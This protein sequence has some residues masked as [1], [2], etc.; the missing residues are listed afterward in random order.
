MSVIGRKTWVDLLRGVAMTA[1]LFFHTDVY[2]AD[3]DVLGYAFY[4]QNALT[5][6]FFLSGYLF[7]K[8]TDFSSSDSLIGKSFVR[9]K[10]ASVARNLMIPYFVFAL[11]LS[12]PKAYVRQIPLTSLLMDILSGRAFWFVAALI[13]AELLF[14]LVLRITRG[15]AWGLLT[16]AV[17][18][19]VACVL[20]ST[21]GPELYADY[22]WQAENAIMAVVFLCLGWLF[23][24][25]EAVFDRF[26]R[27]SYISLL[28]LLTIIIKI[29]EHRN[30]ISMCIEP[31]LVSHWTLFY[32]DCITVTILMLC[33][34][35]RMPRVKLTE[36]TG[37]HSIVYYFFCSSVPLAVSLFLGKA[38]LPYHGSIWRAL[39]AFIIAYAAITAIAWVI[40]RYLPFI[41]GHGKGK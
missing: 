38:G 29:Y 30:S 31:I 33:V 2:Y 26:N 25:Y 14:L 21:T 37:A 18:A 4:V 15:K 20:L 24:R 16:T 41:I 3:D 11:I 6:F 39:V 34:V 23:H 22:P 12:V 19:A 8:E 32:A 7:F 1:I 36:W 5:I 40:Y 27:P 10:M 13:V 17:V 35:K 28:L 9:H